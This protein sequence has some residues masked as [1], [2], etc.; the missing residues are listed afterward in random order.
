MD[1]PGPRAN[2]LE[3]TF[4]HVGFGRASGDGPGSPYWVQK[5]GANATC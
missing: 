1:S 2:I 5:F 4:T 3:P